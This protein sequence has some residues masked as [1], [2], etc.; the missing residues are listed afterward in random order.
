MEKKPA[1]GIRPN[2]RKKRPTQAKS[3][4]EIAPA[5]SLELHEWLDGIHRQ[6][7]SSA[8]A[9]STQGA[10]LVDDPETGGKVCV[11]TDE[12]TCT[13]QLKGE[14]IGGPCGPD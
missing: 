7:K 10:C 12:V 1:K 5:R 2:T 6:A 14:W 9:G 13:T 3:L 11:R 8:A 4:A